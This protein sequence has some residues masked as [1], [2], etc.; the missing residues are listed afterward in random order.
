MNTQI[1]LT[2]PTPEQTREVH[3]CLRL[4]QAERTRLNMLAKRLNVPTAV[5]VRHI[6]FQAVDVYEEQAGTID[7]ESS[8]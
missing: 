3:Y 8:E 7:G 6:L 2:L 4:T 5:M 1:A